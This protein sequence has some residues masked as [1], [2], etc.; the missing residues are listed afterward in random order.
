MSKSK[1]PTWSRRTVL[2][3]TACAAT[4]GLPHVVRD[5]LAA[6]APQAAANTP[7]PSGAATGKAA[8]ATAAPAAS[9]TP[10]ATGPATPF[11]LQAVRLKPSVF[12][13]A[14]ESNGAYLLRLEPD[15]LLHNFRVSAK[16]PPKGAVYGGWESLSLAGHSLGHYLSACSLMFAQTGNPAYRERINYIIV[17]LLQCQQAHG[18]GYVGGFTR[19][20]GDTDEDGKIIFAEIARGEIH[21]KPFSLNGAWSPLYTLHKLFAGLLDAEEY[22]HNA[23]ALKIA[24]GLGDYLDRTFSGLSEEQMQQVLACEYGG[25]NES[26][27]ELHERT[28]DERWLR[29]ARRLYDHKVLD[30]LANELDELE[31][32]HSNTQVP[33]VIGLARLHEVTGD[34][35]Y[36]TA[37]QFFWK[38]VTRDRSYV[39][40]GNADRECFQSP[41]SQYITE[42][43][44]EACN[45]Y[46][47][48]KLTRHLYQWQP[49]AAYFDYY[50]RAHLN[51][52]LAQ[53]H[54]TTGMFAY[55]M[56]LMSGARREF[57]KPFDDFW[58]C[59]GTG[60]ESHSKHGDSIYWKRGDELLVNLYIPTELTWEEQ[61]ATLT[62]RTSYPH[63]GNVTLE[64]ARLLTPRTFAV[65]FRI[66]A[67]CKSSSLTVNGKAEA[68]TQTQQGYVTLR[69]NWQT[70][71][72][73]EL[74][75]A[76]HLRA[77]PMR[78]DHS[79]IA[80]MYGPM[81]MAADLGAA[82]Q[83]FNGASPV[84]IGATTTAV[85]SAIGAR[86]STGSVSQPP[87]LSLQPFFEQYDRRSAVYFSR[88]TDQQWQIAQAA[89]MAEKARTRQLD[90][91]TLDVLRF[92]DDRSEHEHLLQTGKSES[93]L[94]RGRNGRLARGGSTFELRMRVGSGPQSLQVT[95]W[96]R[97][98]DSRFRILADGLPVGGE[99]MDGTG[100]IA[101]VE[102]T[103]ELPPRV[104]KG[105]E[106]V[107]FRFEPEPDAGAGPVFGCRVLAG[108]PTSA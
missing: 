24:E 14:V 58:C 76:M 22:C 45:T 71:D 60:M 89:V 94:Y 37:A 64:A 63:G 72:K 41:L 79:V 66:P 4:L 70:G 87:N 15:R 26:F 36:G 46:N 48:L 51:H 30:A 106:F 61:G 31:G 35:S 13:T 78:D 10:A 23:A 62:L 69:R 8:P 85:L 67:W 1:R 98:R 99:S 86:T 55:M 90:A 47:M 9:P 101:F 75:L 49:D 16:L 102:R 43:T 108:P 38:T 95:Y 100:P 19:K 27:A 107:V 53:H 97:Q 18:D 40:G 105:K 77:E 2:Q 44:C 25:L 59:M 68:D 50:E 74:K 42:Q 6:D 81:V 88:L 104:T 82:S 73:V 17:E 92:G 34:S 103:Y 56:P 21:A 39:I 11:P 28:G 96:G 84:L 83:P 29:L 93:V 7:R 52:I 80:L 33:K 91:H 57:S 65:S 5:V 32:V 20:Q 54:P 12:L 3:G